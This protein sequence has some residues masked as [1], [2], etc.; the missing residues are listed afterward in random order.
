MSQNGTKAITDL[1][2][3]YLAQPIRWLL[4]EIEPIFAAWMKEAATA[5]EGVFTPKDEPPKA[6]KFKATWPQ[7]APDHTMVRV[8]HIH[9]KPPFHLRIYRRR[10]P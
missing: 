4:K 6:S 9:T 1:D 10:T 5:L 8:S 3:R 7:P 2:N